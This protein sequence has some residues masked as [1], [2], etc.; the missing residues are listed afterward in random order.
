[1]AA[2]LLACTSPVD[3]GR[4][5]TEPADSSPELFSHPYLRPLGDGYAPS[6]LHVMSSSPP[7][8]GCIRTPWDFGAANA[9]IDASLE[10]EEMAVVHRLSGPQ[11]AL[12]RLVEALHVAAQD[13]VAEA[14]LA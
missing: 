4:T 1:M 8:W 5:S 6:P 9:A 12:Q 3:T 2:L 10:R 14:H 11:A 13:D 7:P